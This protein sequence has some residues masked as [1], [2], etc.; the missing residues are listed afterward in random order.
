MAAVM[1]MPAFAET[2]DCSGTGHW[3]TMSALSRLKFAGI[4]DD[5]VSAKTKTTRIASERIGK[6]LYRQVHRVTFTE[7][8]GKIIDGREQRIE[9][10][11]LNEWRG[12]IRGVEASG[13]ATVTPNPRF[14]TDP[15][16]Q[17]FAP[18]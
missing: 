17:R 12:S 1:V 2:P 10:R 13:G 16:Q 9:R 3:P 4:A 5:V 6:D 11:M 8:S 15:P 7:V 14:D 18:L